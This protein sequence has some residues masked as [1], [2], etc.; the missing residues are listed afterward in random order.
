MSYFDGL[1]NMVGPGKYR[2]EISEEIDLFL[3]SYLDVNPLYGP[4]KQAASDASVIV[5]LIDIKS[6]L[7]QKLNTLKLSHSELYDSLNTAL[8]YEKGTETEEQND[9]LMK[10][11]CGDL[12]LLGLALSSQKSELEKM[13]QGRQRIGEKD[14]IKAFVAERFVWIW[15]SYRGWPRKTTNTPE[16]ETLEYVYEVL[17]LPLSGVQGRLREAI[18]LVKNTKK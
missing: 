15:Q 2:K 11:I 12:R 9:F 10:F 13:M 4:I 18:E 5:E 7:I 3:R 14:D 6:K 17:E 1:Y 16:L 8:H